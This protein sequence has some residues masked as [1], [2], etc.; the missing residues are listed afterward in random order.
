MI[1]STTTFDKSKID[2]ITYLLLEHLS[3][4]LDILKTLAGFSS[5]PIPLDPGKLLLLLFVEIIESK[6]RFLGSFLALGAFGI[7]VEEV[8]PSLLG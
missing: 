4:A 7:L 6:G 8:L 2:N 1:F 3:Q 5:T